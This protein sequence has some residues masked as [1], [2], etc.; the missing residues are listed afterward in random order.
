MSS[1]DLNDYDLIKY[2]SDVENNGLKK[3]WSII[4][5]FVLNSDCIPEFLNVNNFG[6]LYEIGLATEDKILKKKSGQYYT[7]DDVAN[8]MTT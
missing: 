4:C 8:V 5:D 3:T 1:N 2:I 6:E 7:P